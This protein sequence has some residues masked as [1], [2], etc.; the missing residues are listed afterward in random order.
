M[1]VDDHR[2]ALLQMFMAFLCGG[3]L[4]YLMAVVAYEGAIC[5]PLAISVLVVV[6]SALL[7][8]LLS[9]RLAEVTVP[10]F[11]CCCLFDLGLSIV[12]LTDGNPRDVYLWFA[13]I[14]ILMLYARGLSSCLVALV[15]VFAQTTVLRYVAEAP[16][17]APGFRH[18]RL[19]TPLRT[20]FGIRF[21]SFWVV[22]GLLADGSTRLCAHTHDNRRDTGRP[23]V[24][25]ADHLVCSGQPHSAHA[26]AQ[27]AAAGARGPRAGQ[28]Q[29]AAGHQGQDRLPGQHEPR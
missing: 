26:S 25:G 11:L 17:A 9:F 28:H 2:K 15:F 16:F 18:T 1:P 12:T 13:C 27:A 7:V 22:A 14:P 8:L 10:L 6:L 5:T 21:R 24:S 20:F 19:G 29:A 23:V 3:G 4:L